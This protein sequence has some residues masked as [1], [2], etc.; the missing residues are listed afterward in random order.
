AAQ[1][2][3]ACA[4]SRPEDVIQ[5]VERVEV[6]GVQL[7]RPVEDDLD[8]VTVT[9]YAYGHGFKPSLSWVEEHEW[10]VTCRSPL[11][12]AR[13]SGSTGMSARS[14]AQVPPAPV[15]SSRPCRPCHRAARPGRC[16]TLPLRT[17]TAHRH[18]PATRH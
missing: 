14:R 4:G 5:L 3:G 12:R 17:R 8:D 16:R 15:R 1:H 11:R 9:V 7:L 18:A 13:W 10:G 6:E 2:E